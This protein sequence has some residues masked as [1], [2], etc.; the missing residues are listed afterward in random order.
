M[1]WF[2]KILLSIALINIAIGPA[3]AGGLTKQER[4]K[5]SQIKSVLDPMGYRLAVDEQ[6]KKALVYDTSTNT[7]AMEIPFGEEE[8]LRKFSP[9]SLNRMLLDEMVLIKSAGA[10]AFSHSIKALPTESLIFFTAMGAVVAGQLITNY[11]Q[12]PVAMQEHIEHQLSPVG[13]FGFYLFMSSQGLTSNVLA[14]YMKN[15]KYH[16]LIPYLGMAVGS[17]V[18]SYMSQVVSDPNVRA[19]GKVMI[20]AKVTQTDLDAGVDPDPCAKAYEYLVLK[21]KIWEFAPGMVS[22]L[23]SSGLAA[24][25]QAAVT[26][27]VLKVTGVDLALW[28]VPGGMEVKGLRLMLVKGIQISLFVAIDNWLNS[29]VTFAWKNLFDG[30][31]FYGMNNNLI[32]QVN[33]LNRSQWTAKNDELKNQLKNFH[34]KM[35][36]WRMV[37][38]ADV[39]AAHQAWSENLHQLIGMH[40]ASYAYYNAFLNEVRNV[41]FN[42]QYVKPLLISYPLNGVLAKG[43]EAGK[44]DLYFQAPK[45]I[46]NSQADTVADVVASM[47]QFTNTGNGKYLFPQEKK[48]FKIIRDLLANSDRMKIG[49]GLQLLNREMQQAL[50]NYTASREFVTEL[51]LITKQLG[52]PAPALEPG[53]GFL[54][55][56]ETAPSTAAN[57]KD[58]AYYLKVGLFYTPHITDYLTMQM[59]C[60]PDVDSGQKMIK[61][62]RGFPSVFLP[63][64]I[65]NQNDEFDVACD[66]WSGKANAD[67]I[68]KWPIQLKN[69]KKYVGFLSYLTDNTRPS[70]VGSVNSAVFPQWWSQKTESQMQTA[71]TEYEKDY[72]QIVVDLVR[73]IYREKRETYSGV[74]AKYWDKL[75]TGT[76]NFLDKRFWNGDRTDKSTF[77]RGPVSNGTINSAF[78]E[79]RVYLSILKELFT[80]SAQFQMDIATILGKAP[81]EIHLKAVENQFAVLNGLLKHIKIVQLDGREAIHSD[82]ENYQLEEQLQK[83][84]AALAQVSSVLGV[85]ENKQNVLV[86]LTPAQQ[87]V[88]VL[89]LENLQTL[90][91]EIMMYGSMANAVSWDKIRNVK[92]ANVAQGKFN[93]EIQ[94]QL[95]KL[96]GATSPLH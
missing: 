83:I 50:Q 76:K 86:K 17:F 46:E 32:S 84:Q 48:T 45:M 33:I 63:P 85:G 66:S 44:E 55:T 8:N 60:G 37:N 22:M 14:M 7:L 10:A 68:Y 43:L 26:R 18:Q 29:R 79:E 30:N 94:K 53:R 5:I 24:F 52:H 74:F 82:L 90:A 27:T 49:E 15:P 42:Q 47:D 20:G 11:S 69:Q 13:L 31:D 51:T 70:V 36:E 75:S 92:Q 61:N 88:A 23:A 81:T 39:Y 93:N 3:F 58:T 78:Q 57:F 25:A 38:L 59:I 87:E 72:D 91:S 67:Q 80:P 2:S 1:K 4:T 19:C 12:N 71:F 64:Q 54:A 16:H 73:T 62:A 65:K 41:R 95:S 35:T 56:Y 96:R 34:T 21:K 89:C 40:N 77:N 9:K 28:L 6:A